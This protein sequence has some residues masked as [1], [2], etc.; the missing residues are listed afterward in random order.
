MNI[1]LPVC[2]AILLPTMVVAAET[3]DLKGDWVGTTQPIVA[4][5]GGPHWPANRGTWDKPA[6]VERAMT[7]RI[8]GQDGRRFWGK[9][10][11]G[12]DKAL[13]AEATEEPFVGTLAP[14]GTSFIIADT[15]GYFSGRIT[16]TTL[17][18]CYA[19]AGA[20]KEGD[21]PAV[22]TCLEVTKK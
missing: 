2:F 10:I 6:L 20:K 9:S 11:V 3:P 16:G 18:Y 19:Q 14:D 12:A 7:I 13:G 17:S 15:D 4:G 5:H 22:A 8:V 1:C 21:G